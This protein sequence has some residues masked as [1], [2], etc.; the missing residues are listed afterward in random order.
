VLRKRQNLLVGGL[1]SFLDFGD[2]R[3]FDGSQAE[4]K[5]LGLTAAESGSEFRKSHLTLKHLRHFT[6]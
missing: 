1:V 6:L 4:R 3:D 5:S 2:G